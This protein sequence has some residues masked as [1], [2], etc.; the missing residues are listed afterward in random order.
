M[1]LASSASDGLLKLWN[2]RTDECIATMDNHTD[3]VSSV[4]NIV[5]ILSN[6]QVWA[7]A[8]SSDEST[9]VTGGADSVITFWKDCTKEVEQEKEEKRVQIVQKY[10]VP[11]YFTDALELS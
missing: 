10:C 7:L 5:L 11:V 4:V 8:V 2:V 1:Q 3:K 9:I 6:S